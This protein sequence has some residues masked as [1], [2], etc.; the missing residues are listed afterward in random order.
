MNTLEEC[1]NAESC[2]VLLFSNFVEVEQKHFYEEKYCFAGF[3]E[4]YSKCK[5]FQ[6]KKVLGFCPEFVFPDS[7]MTMEEIIIKYE[8]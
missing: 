3:K 5:R 1:P 4:G 7:E 2:P 6:T 8:E